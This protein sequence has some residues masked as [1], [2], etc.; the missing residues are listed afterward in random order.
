MFM[1]SLMTSKLLSSLH[2]VPSAP[3]N[4]TVADKTST[5][6]LVTWMPPSIPNGVLIKFEISYSGISS[7]NP[8]PSSFHQPQYRIIP[9]PGTSILLSDLVPYSNYTISVR[10]FTS[11]GPGEYSDVIEDRTGKDGDYSKAILCFCMHNNCTCNRYS[12]FLVSL[13]T[14]PSTPLNVTVAN[15]TSTTLL[16]I[17]MPP[18]TPNGVLTSYEVYLTGVFSVNSVNTSFFRPFS[19][20]IS[21]PTTSLVLSDLVPYSNYTI[22]VRAFTSAGPGE[23]SEVIEDRTEEDGECF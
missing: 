13:H 3:L 20:I 12:A 15:K 17:W 14:V 19:V 1:T 11:A 4:V 18:S 7:E 22:S 21:T 10:A 8:V 2:T 6:L 16:V 23:Y 9:V 5:T